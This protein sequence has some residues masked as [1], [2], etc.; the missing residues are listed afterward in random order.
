MTDKKTN[1]TTVKITIEIQLKETKVILSEEEAYKVHL[2][3]QRIFKQPESTGERVLPIPYPIPYAPYPHPLYPTL[4]W[5]SDTIE[6][7]I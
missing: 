2:A 7:T 6:V 4:T 3:L 1:E 5:C